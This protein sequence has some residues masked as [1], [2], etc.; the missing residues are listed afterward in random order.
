MEQ[1]VEGMKIGDFKIENCETCELNKEKKKTVPKDSY[2]RATRT[3]DLFTDILGPIDP[4]AE[5][6][7]RYSIGFVYSFSRSKKLFHEDE[8]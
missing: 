7:H 6:G 8:I 2:A 4:I 1:H 5:D 3:L